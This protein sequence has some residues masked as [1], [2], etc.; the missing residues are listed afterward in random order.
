[1]VNVRNADCTALII[2]LIKVRYIH[3]IEIFDIFS[4]VGKKGRTERDEKLLTV[5][6]DVLNFS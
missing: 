4:C 6:P 2:V 1:M 5:L 3:L